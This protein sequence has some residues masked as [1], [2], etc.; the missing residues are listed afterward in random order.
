[1]FIINLLSINPSH[2]VSINISIILFTQN[3]IILVYI[4]WQNKS[5]IYISWNSGLTKAV[6]FWYRM[7]KRTLKDNVFE[8]IAKLGLSTSMGGS[9][10]ANLYV[11]II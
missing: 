3:I 4:L 2:L 8:F 9:L 11:R 1:M 10:S 6:A 7:M 5:S